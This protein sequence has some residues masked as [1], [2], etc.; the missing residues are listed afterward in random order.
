MTLTNPFSSAFA[1]NPFSGAKTAKDWLGY[2]K[3]NKLPDFFG[4]EKPEDGSQSSDSSSSY[5]QRPAATFF[6]QDQPLPDLS[7]ATREMINSNMAMYPMYR[8]LLIDSG[9]IAN[10]QTLQSIRSTYPW[11]SKAAEDAARRNF[12][13]SQQAFNMK[14]QSPEY[15]QNIMASK[16][17]QATQAASAEYQRALGMAAQQQ[18]ANQFSYMGR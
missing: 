9:D 3:S 5:E 1:T 10:Q 17:G 11:L 2:Y 6:A 12:Y 8:Q 15:V 18:A 14:Q 4:K 7:P 13:Y 16:Q